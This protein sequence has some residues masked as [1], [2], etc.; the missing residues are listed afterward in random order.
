MC[1]RVPFGAR[2]GVVR[3]HVCNRVAGTKSS[4]TLTSLLCQGCLL[5]VV[6]VSIL[7][8]PGCST[9]DVAFCSRVLGLPGQSRRG[10]R[11]GHRYFVITRRF[12]FMRVSTV[13]TAAKPPP[14]PPPQPAARL[15]RP[16]WRNGARSMLCRSARF[17]ALGDVSAPPPRTMRLQGCQPLMLCRPAHVSAPPQRCAGAPRCGRAL[18]HP[19]AGDWRA[20]ACVWFGLIAQSPQPRAHNP[21][22]VV[23]ADAGGCNGS[24]SS[25]LNLSAQV[26]LTAAAAAATAAAAAAPDRHQTNEAAPQLPLCDRCARHSCLACD[27]A[28]PPDRRHGAQCGPPHSTEKWLVHAPLPPLPRLAGC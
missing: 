10:Q 20:A 15:G 22:C 17:A 23:V 12:C 24:R 13:H 16:G 8:N 2:V 1:C 9:G 18:V 5:V 14:P 27:A 21:G 6:V 3:V 19:A 4:H 7:L 25:D 11:A 28:A 26:S